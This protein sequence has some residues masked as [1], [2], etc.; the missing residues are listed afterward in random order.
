MAYLPERWRRRIARRLRAILRPLGRRPTRAA[1][2]RSDRSGRTG[3]TVRGEVPAP[4]LWTPFLVGRAPTG[5]LISVSVAVV[6]GLVG[7]VIARPLTGV[8]AGAATLLAL[9]VPRTRLLLGLAAVGLMIAAGTYT[10]VEQAHLHASLNGDWASNFEV[11]SNLAW[12]AVV[13][14]GADA[15]V[16]IVRRLVSARSPTGGPTGGPTGPPTG[17]A[18]GSDAVDPSWAREE[19]D[20]AACP[21]ATACRATRTRAR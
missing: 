1:H 10:I 14:L 4:Q 3:L 2:A 15:T 16:E 5:W 13:F 17:T 19:S 18:S 6:T 8:V 7:A 21:S 11:A 20:D 9:L 12:A